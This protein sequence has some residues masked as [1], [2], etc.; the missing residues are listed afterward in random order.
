MSS[1]AS[2]W[3][4]HAVRVLLVGDDQP[5]PDVA[6]RQ[7]RLEVRVEQHLQRHSPVDAAGNGTTATLGTLRMNGNTVH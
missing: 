6:A 4:T 3:P 1:P 2:D 7:A 5:V